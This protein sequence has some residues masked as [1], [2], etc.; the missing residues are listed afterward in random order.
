MILRNKVRT[1]GKD[2]EI[3][4]L[5]NLVKVVKRNEI[6]HWELKNL[7]LSTTHRIKY[8]IISSP[9]IQV[10]LL[11]TLTYSLYSKHTKWLMSLPRHHAFSRPCLNPFIS[12]F[13]NAPSPNTRLALW[14]IRS[15]LFCV[16]KAHSFYRIVLLEISYFSILT[17]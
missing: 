14:N 1:A 7:L 6:A 3:I 11:H 8:K 5:G 12:Y 4:N 2:L 9:L 15:H 13:W 10:Q 17:H 16:S